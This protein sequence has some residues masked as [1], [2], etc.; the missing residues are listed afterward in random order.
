MAWRKGRELVFNASENIEKAWGM[1]GVATYDD[2]Y[3]DLLVYANEN[4]KGLKHTHTTNRRNSGLSSLRDLLAPIRTL[5]KA[6]QHSP[7]CARTV[8]PA[9]L[10]CSDSCQSSHRILRS[11]HASWS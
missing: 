4:N 2:S 9:E 5:E 6:L 10:Q 3:Y 11:F 1:D 7:V 8:A